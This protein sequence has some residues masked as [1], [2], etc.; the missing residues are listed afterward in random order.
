M[1]QNFVHNLILLQILRTILNNIKQ[2]YKGKL[3]NT[4]QIIQKM[5]KN[6]TPPAK[7]PEFTRGEFIIKNARF[8]K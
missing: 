6:K 8:L 3:N 4:T 2:F 7:P 5:H 1:A